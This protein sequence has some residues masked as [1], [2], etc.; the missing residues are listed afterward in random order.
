MSAKYRRILYVFIGFAVFF[1][2]LPEIVRLGAQYGLTKFAAQQATIED[3]DLNLFTGT[4]AIEGV[5]IEYADQ[6]TL[7]LGELRADLDMTALF[8]KRALIEHLQL[9]D[10]TLQVYQQQAQWVVA[11]P[12][13]VAEDADSTPDEPAADAEPWQVGLQSVQLSNVTVD[14]RY[15]GETH[16]V[17]LDNLAVN[18]LF[19]WQPDQQAHLELKGALNDAVLDFNGDLKPFAQSQSFVINLVVDSLNLEPVNQFLPDTLNKIEGQ[20]SLNTQVRIDLQPQGDI[21]VSQ[22]G[23]I[24]VTLDKADGMDLVASVGN[25]RWQGNAVTTIVS[26]QQPVLSL[27]GKATIAKLDA[28]FTPLQLQTQL[29]DLRWQGDVAVDLADLNNSL[30]VAGELSLVDWALLDQASPGTVAEFAHLD[31][32][33]ILLSGLNNVG[34]EQLVLEGFAAMTAN[35]DQNGTAVAPLGQLAELKVADIQL[36]DLHRL[37]I[38]QVTLTDLQGQLTKTQSG[39][40]AYLDPWLAGLQERAAAL[41]EAKVTNT[42]AET[43]HTSEVTTDTSEAKPFTYRVDSLQIQGANQFTFTDASLSPAVVHPI[44]IEKL[45][46]GRLDADKPDAA[47]PVEAALALY[48]YGSLKLTGS[49]TPLQPLAKMNAD[50][51]TSIKGIEL[52]DLAPYLQNAM[53]YHANSGQFNADT[54]ARIEQGK[55]DSETNVKILR[56]DLE[57]VDEEAIA[58]L[59]KKLTMPVDTALNIITDSDNTL[60]LTVPVKG[61]LT[62][63]D[64]HIDRIVAGAVTQAVKNAAFTYFKYAV[65]PFGAIMLVSEKIGDMSLQAKFEPARFVPGTAD[66]VPKQT[67]Y[68]EKVAAMIKEKKDFSILVC[69][70]VTEQDFA[71]RQDLPKLAEGQQR[72]WDPVSEALAKERLTFIKNSLIKEHGL[73]ADR[74]QSCRPQLGEGEPRAIMGI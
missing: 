30:A 10:V 25:V 27:K 41:S 71:V 13:P 67:G 18:D 17:R 36:Q 15:Q 28:V 58:R 23:E 59:S 14:A 5:T 37:H 73:T 70:M 24:A 45:L 2:V 60:A 63:P 34:L 56:M 29:S 68:L 50:I 65:Q 69:V 44:K 26:N 8:G 40:L 1:W 46:I 31:L 19:M 52:P 42:D 12:I 55:L 6:P 39:E 47:T 57:P 22:D 32:Q 9:S 3:I 49:A 43:E 11:L 66:M 64:I 21:T 38:A 54:V 35:S 62:N 48:E 20:V 74:V 51:K 61:D 16:R 53:G 33:E 7:T 72:Q 4:A